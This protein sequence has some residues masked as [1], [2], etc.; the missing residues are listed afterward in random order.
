M[1]C[2]KIALA[3]VG[4]Q[5]HDDSFVTPEF[6]GQRHLVMLWK[7]IS[8]IVFE[9]Y[10][11]MWSIGNMQYKQ[12]WVHRRGGIIWINCGWKWWTNWMDW[13]KFNLKWSIYI[14]GWVTSSDVSVQNYSLRILFDFVIWDTC[15]DTYFFRTGCSELLTEKMN[16]IVSKLFSRI[17][18]RWKKIFL[19]LVS[20]MNY[21]KQK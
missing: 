2:C 10:L 5:L 14:S 3:Q 9:V 8:F 19:T 13:F 7:P 21:G 1:S 12:T 15:F 4:F 11:S 20:F 6:L 17:D 16:A 18:L